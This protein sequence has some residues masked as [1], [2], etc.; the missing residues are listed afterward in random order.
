M[1]LAEDLHDSAGVVDVDGDVD[2]LS[3]QDLITIVSAEA[4]TVQAERRVPG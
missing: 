2:E 4:S 3:I 1:L